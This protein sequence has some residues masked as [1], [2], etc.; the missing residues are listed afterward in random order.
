MAGYTHSHRS[1]RDAV[2]AHM[3]IHH[4]I[5]LLSSR[6]RSTNSGS[7]TSRCAIGLIRL[8]M[9]PRCTYPSLYSFEVYQQIAG[10]CYAHACA[11]ALGSAERRIV[12]RKVT[13]HEELVR[14]IVEL[15]G[16]YGGNPKLVLD[17]QCPKRHLRYRVCTAEGTSQALQHR[18]T[19]I[20]SFHLDD[21]QW[22]RFTEFYIKTDPEGILTNDVVAPTIKDRLIGHAMAIVGE[23]E[24]DG[25]PYWKFKN[26][27]GSTFAD[28]GCCR[29]SK[30]ALELTFFDVFFFAHELPPADL[31]NFASSPQQAVLKVLVSAAYGP[32]G[33]A[34]SLQKDDEIEVVFYHCCQGLLVPTPALPYGW[35][36]SK[37]MY[38]VKT[39]HTNTLF[40][41][42]RGDRMAQDL[43]DSVKA[44]EVASSY[45]PGGIKFCVP[46]IAS[47]MG[48]FN[49]EGHPIDSWTGHY[50]LL[51]NFLSGKYQKFLFQPSARDLED[52]Q[53]FFHYS[54]VQ[55]GRKSIIWDLQGVRSGE[56]FILTDPYIVTEAA[57]SGIYGNQHQTFGH[58][59]KN[60]GDVCQ[61]AGISRAEEENHQAIRKA[62]DGAALARRDERFF[63]DAFKNKS[64]RRR[65]SNL[66][67]TVSQP[68]LSN[69]VIDSHGRSAIVSEST[70]TL[71][72]LSPPTI[73]RRSPVSDSAGPEQV[74][75]II[76]G[77][78]NVGKTQL[79]HRYV[80]GEVADASCSTIGPEFTHKE[81]KLSS[82]DTVKAQLWDTA[83]QERYLAMTQ[84]Y[85]RNASGALLVY[86]ITNELTFLECQI[87]L[88][89]LRETTPE[90]IVIALVGNKLDLAVA[91]PTARKV[92]SDKAE[93]FAKKHGLICAE[94]SAVKNWNIEE[95]FDILLITVLAQVRSRA[96]MSKPSGPRTRTR[97]GAKSAQSTLTSGNACAC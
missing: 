23:G 80:Y 29:I 73:P 20:G 54:Y 94:A 4:T 3:E 89:S 83:E 68:D 95:M 76:V 45:P 44:A 19:V 28:D 24:R 40:A 81:V 57:P 35:G 13:P 58:L 90:D 32:G 82:R 77:K 70:D 93:A 88:N 8:T 78:S 17:M 38:L 75:I 16:E 64:A 12:G 67:R 37:N 26:S 41:L 47:V 36:H 79:L 62:Q 69:V 55:S 42:K 5:T 96:S 30:S 97:E 85:Y 63:T 25:T 84:S 33:F 61:Q 1:Y 2:H 27:W 91:N 50:C 31:A 46:V 34:T 56:N 7:A 18:R 48:A 22:G 14:E 59:H 53:A 71:A 87:W 11:T 10:T 43:R 65:G 92:A 66:K 52:M 74:K 49:H 60:C 9:K 21:S 51:E 86:E 6:C 72:P 39:K 15:H